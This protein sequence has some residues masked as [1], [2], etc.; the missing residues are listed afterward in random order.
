MAGLVP[1]IHVFARQDCQETWIAGTSPGIR[2]WSW[3]WSRA[4][5]RAKRSNPSRGKKVRMLR[6][7]APLRNARV[8]RSND[9][10]SVY[11][12]LFSRIRSQIA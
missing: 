12:R 9:V 10:A 6:R 11:A 5:L 7:F 2:V 4:S 1:A 3:R 8:C